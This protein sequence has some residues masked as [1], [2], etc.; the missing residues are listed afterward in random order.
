MII[1]YFHDKKYIAMNAITLK[2]EKV[3][4]ICLFISYL[5]PSTNKS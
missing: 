5:F 3:F 4:H 2:H 1:A